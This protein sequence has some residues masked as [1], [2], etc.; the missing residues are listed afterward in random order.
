MNILEA[1][2]NWLED[3]RHEFLSSVI[4]YQTGD[5]RFELA[6]TIGKTEFEVAD[7]FGR[8]LK[9]CSRDFLVLSCD[10]KLSDGSQFKPQLGDKILEN[11]FCYE[12]L[13]PGDKQ[14]W[15]F[16]DPF[17]KSIRIHTKLIGAEND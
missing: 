1:G 3:Q 5:Y 2:S 12:V 9:F 11:G 15:R 16:S 13:A 8:F 17:Q 7:E 14:C 6:A 10:L 4:E